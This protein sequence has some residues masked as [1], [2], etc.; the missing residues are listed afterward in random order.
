M[1]NLIMVFII[2]KLIILRMEQV[3]KVMTEVINQ[4][5]RRKGKMVKKNLM[6][7]TMKLDSK[8]FNAANHKAWSS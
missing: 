2:N 8:S 6:T 5:K 1:G 4:R 3:K 7:R